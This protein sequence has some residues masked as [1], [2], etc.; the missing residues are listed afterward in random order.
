MFILKYI[1]KPIYTVL[2]F[3]IPK[4][5]KDDILKTIFSTYPLLTML[6]TLKSLAL[7]IY[8]VI[9]ST[10]KNLKLKIYISCVRYK[11]TQ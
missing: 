1:Q 6:W 7:I 11:E 2:K 9:T 4:K 10:I 8:S 5:K 3:Y